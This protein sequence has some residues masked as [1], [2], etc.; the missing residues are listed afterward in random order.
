MARESLTDGLRLARICGAVPLG[1]ETDSEL[2]LLGSRTRRVIRAGA[3]ELTA[4]ERRVA[5]LAADGYSNQQIADAL[6]VSIRTVEAH[7]AHVYQKLDIKSRRQLA[8]A[9]SGGA[10]ASAPAR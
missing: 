4:A 10:P 1:R 5:R 9:L 6:V 2:S 7:L 8:A 3:E